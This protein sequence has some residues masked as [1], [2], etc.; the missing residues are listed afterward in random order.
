MPRAKNTPI[1]GMANEDRVA[2]K[3]E[4]TTKPRTNHDG[5]SF[6]VEPQRPPPRESGPSRNAQS[7]PR[8]PL[9]PPRR[10]DEIDSV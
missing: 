10:A 9:R 5:G 8:R 1:V 7:S 2:E 4:S 3:K 6:F